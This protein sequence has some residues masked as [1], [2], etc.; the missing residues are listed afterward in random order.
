MRTRVLIVLTIFSL[1]AVAGLVLPLLATTSQART[2]ALLLSRVATLDR[3][4]AL[5]REVRDAGDLATVQAEASRITEVYGEDLLLV[6]PS[7]H[8]LMSTGSLDLNDPGVRETLA[9]ASRNLA[10]TTL[11]PVRP[12][13]ER[14]HLLARPVGTPHELAGAVVLRVDAG[15]AISGVRRDWALIVTGAVA[16]ELLLLEL[17]IL[18]TR[19]VVRPVRR[20]EEAVVGL[21]ETPTT[22]P[23]V[24][25]SGPPEL[26][27]LTRSFADMAATVTRSLEMQRRMVADSS[28]QLRNPLA[29]V[30]L[31]LDALASE[32]RD[33]SS[34]RF[35]GIQQDLD[36]LEALLNDLLRL[37]EAESRRPDAV[38][39]QS[40]VSEVLPGEVGAW[41]LLAAENGVDLAAELAAV[42]PVAVSETDL[43]Q[44]VGALVDNAI[45]YAG[46]GARVTVRIEKS[47]ADG[48][49]LSVVDDGPGLPREQ[50]ELALQRFWR[51]DQHQS[52]RGSGLG[53]AIV[54]QLVSAA[55]GTLTIEAVTPHGLA[56][57]VDLRTAI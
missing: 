14:R 7:G 57:H 39:G 3:L 10:Q 56:V 5:A 38:A 47:G 43:R 23:A 42:P 48:V 36:R 27:H 44:I 16:A 18:L 46:H 22:G 1:V 49:R 55:G 40:V 41:R 32:L 8:P 28:H 6:G 2:Q 29:A 37:A 25:L 20:L 21:A 45:K 15:R 11:D 19:W 50:R 53:L 9:S 33:P 12:W 26:R 34:P 52:P 13:S 54:D 24:M 30:R 51:A 35:A 17:A 4:A 31:R